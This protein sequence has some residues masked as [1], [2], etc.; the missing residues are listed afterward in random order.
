MTDQWVSGLV[1]TVVTTVY[2][3]YKV[4]VKGQNHS[5]YSEQWLMRL[6][7]SAIE[8]TT[9]FFNEQGLNPCPPSWF[10]EVQEKLVDKKLI[11]RAIEE[12]HASKG[13]PG[14]DLNAIYKDLKYTPNMQENFITFIRVA[15]A[16]NLHFCILN[17]NRG[18]Q[19]F[20]RICRSLPT[21]QWNASEK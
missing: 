6:I 5:I 19:N 17:Q 18:N 4:V 15:F 13:T 20:K 8:G 16:V 11:E 12:V 1:D 2:Y 21:F 10:K 7:K 14:M 3:L 9:D